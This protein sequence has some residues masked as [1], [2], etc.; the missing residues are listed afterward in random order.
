VHPRTMKDVNA[1][2]QADVLACSY[3]S[4]NFAKRDHVATELTS[5]MRSNWYHA[6]E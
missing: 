6:G 1:H 2:S 4:A 3:Y 5:A